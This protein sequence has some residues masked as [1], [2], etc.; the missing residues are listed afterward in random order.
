MSVPQSN[1]TQTI[2]SP[3]PDADRTRRTS[4]APFI[5][6]SMGKVTSVS[7]SSGASP[8]ASVMIVTVGRFKFGKTSMGS[9]AACRPPKITRTTV[10]ASTSTRFLRQKAIMWLSMKTPRRPWTHPNYFLTASMRVSRATIAGRFAAGGFGHESD[11]GKHPVLEQVVRVFHLDPH[12]QDSHLLVH[13]GRDA[14]H[15]ALGLQ[16][17]IGRKMN[18]GRLTKVDAMGVFLVHVSLDPDLGQVVNLKQGAFSADNLSGHDVETCDPTGRRSADGNRLHQLGTSAG[19][20][21]IGLLQSSR[22]PRVP[23][24]REQVVA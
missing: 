16:V 20:R 3:M 13:L 18:V 8:C 11:A 9:C 2:D 7:T 4:L 5:A 17:G 6:D 12:R 14:H 24:R 1:S 15:L 21:Q 23:R 22:W 10:T 19:L